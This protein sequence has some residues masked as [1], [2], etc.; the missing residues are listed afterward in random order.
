MNALAVGLHPLKAQLDIKM[1]ESIF[2]IVKRAKYYQGRNE[3]RKT[4]TNKRRKEGREDR[5]IE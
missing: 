1:K 3:A 5:G 2:V 4:G